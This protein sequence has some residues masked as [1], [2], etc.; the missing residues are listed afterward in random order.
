[1]MRPT[2]RAFKRLLSKILDVT[3]LP[4]VGSMPVAHASSSS[5]DRSLKSKDGKYSSG[6]FLQTHSHQ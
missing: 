4:P 1:M 5:V 2:S 6:G 3:S